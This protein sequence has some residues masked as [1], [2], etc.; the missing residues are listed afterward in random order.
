MRKTLV[1]LSAAA[2]VGCS[3]VPS[4]EVGE[5]EDPLF[6]SSPSLTLYSEAGFW[7]DQ[8]TIT[9]SPVLEESVRLVTKTQIDAAN[10]GNRISAARLVCGQR[11]GDVLLFKEFNTAPGIGDWATYGNGHRIHCYAGETKSVNLHVDASAFA[12]HVG[13]VYFVSHAR[14]AA[15]FAFTD[16]F[17][18]AWEARMAEISGYHVSPD[19]GPH[20]RLAS[21]SRF[22]VVQYLH[23]D[24]EFC[25]ARG[26]IL[27]LAAQ[28]YQDGH[29]GVIVVSTY[30]DTGWGDTWG[31]RDIME[32]KLTSGALK[33]ASKLA[34]ALDDV[35][36]IYGTQPRDYFTPTYSLREFRLMTG[37]TPP[38][39]PIKTQ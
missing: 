28:L 29:F 20:L 27:E 24:D 23:L 14:E 21:S 2:L 19:G 11:E 4:E 25:G 15:E 1:L 10:L 13:S 9:I 5:G 7:G 39:P 30:V 33:A 37:G 3:G 31:C 16:F 32:N 35:L 38:E 8:M 22:N 36:A 12:D 17:T 26:G 18:L 34:E 6:W